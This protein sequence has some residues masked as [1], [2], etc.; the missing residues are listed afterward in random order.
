MKRRGTIKQPAAPSKEG[1]AGATEKNTQPGWTPLL[2][3]SSQEAETTHES[4]E[5]Y[6]R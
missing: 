5:S 4:L 3:G 6:R 2:T 1:A